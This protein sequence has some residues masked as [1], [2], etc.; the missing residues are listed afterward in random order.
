MTPNERWYS[1]N[2]QYL[3]SLLPDCPI[4]YD[5]LEATWV[6]IV[7]FPLPANF[8]QAASDLLLL[9][10]G[11]HRP[12][13]DTPKHFYIDQNLRSVS[14]KRPDH[15]FEHHGAPSRNGYAWFSFHL[16]R[17]RPTPDVFSGDNLADVVHTIYQHLGM[18]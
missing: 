1:I 13:S 6:R 16:K 2:I 12:I 11:L 8:R 18:L 9:L 15:I 10:P 5:D 7:S 14:G 3:A 17:W 4:D